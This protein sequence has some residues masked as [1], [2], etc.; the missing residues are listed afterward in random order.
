M[1]KLKAE[2]SNYHHY[3]PFLHRQ[4]QVS[5]KED[6]PYKPAIENINEFLLATRS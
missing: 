2:I 5:S 6:L 1:S 3:K 4:Q